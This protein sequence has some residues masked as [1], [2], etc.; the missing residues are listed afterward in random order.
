LLLVLL[1]AGLWG[2]LGT[3]YKLGTDAFGLTPLTVV[4]WRATLAGLV[5]AVV[6]G[7]TALLAGKGWGALRVRRADLPIFVAFGLLGVTAFYLLYI[8]AVVL[9]GVAVAVVLLYTAPVFVALMSWRFLGEGFGARKVAALAL[10]LL[11]CALV[12]RIYNPD[13]LQVSLVGILCGLASGF[14]YALYS[15]LGKLSLRRGYPIATMSLYV[16]GIGAAG[17]LVV[18]VVGGGPAGVGQLFAMGADPTAW[19]LLLVLALAQTIGALYAYTAGLRHLDAA[20]AS[21]TATFEPLVA[22]CLAYFVLHETLEWPQL[23]GGALIL[24]AVM[25]LQLPSRRHLVVAEAE[26]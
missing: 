19:G 7:L 9:V 11:G 3:A 13:L 15:I 17:L 25:L 6:L 2:T 10:T 12:A 26:T 22:A 1:A 21:V 5:L 14:T 4:F 20:T 18:A 24:G 23:L 16:Y 8:Y